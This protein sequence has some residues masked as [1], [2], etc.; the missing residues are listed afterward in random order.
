MEDPVWGGSAYYL[1]E[2]QRIA[3][4]TDLTATGQI[5]PQQPQKTK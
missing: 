4:Y 3:L 1:Y 2:N 5:Y